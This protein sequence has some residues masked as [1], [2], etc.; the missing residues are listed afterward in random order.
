[1]RKIIS[2]AT[3]LRTPIKT[4]LTLLLVTAVTFGLLTQT[5]EYAVTNRE[6]NNN[7]E[8]Y[9]GTGT[10]EAEEAVYKKIDYPYYIESD[11]RVDAVEIEELNNLQY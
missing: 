1:M 4:I 9:Y 8:R 5:A 7:V 2:A 3:L 6:F 11:P 10:V